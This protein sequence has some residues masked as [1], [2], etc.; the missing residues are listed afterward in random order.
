MPGFILRQLPNAHALTEA[1]NAIKNMGNVLQLSFPY[2]VLI[3]AIARLALPASKEIG[4]QVPLLVLPI[5]FGVF[6][7]YNAILGARSRGPREVLRKQQ[8]SD[9][10]FVSSFAVLTPRCGEIPCISPQPNLRNPEIV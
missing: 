3:A 1:K 6:K 2:F 8:L 10:Q 5:M 4:W 7:S 9:G